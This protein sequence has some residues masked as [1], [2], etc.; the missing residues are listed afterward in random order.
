[1]ESLFTKASVLLARLVVV[2]FFTFVYVTPLYIFAYLIIFQATDL[3]NEISLKCY[4][5]SYSIGY[6]INYINL[7]YSSKNDKKYENKGD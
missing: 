3:L 1:M 7:N 4:I 5:I 6:V 2:G